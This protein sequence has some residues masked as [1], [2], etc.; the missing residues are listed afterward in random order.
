MSDKLLNNM[1][2]RIMVD[3]AADMEHRLFRMLCLLASVISLFIVIPSNIFQNIPILVNIFVGIFGF[4]T[5]ALYRLSISGRHFIMT[6]FVLLVLVLDSTW[7]LNGGT[8][9]SVT[10]YFFCA[11]MYPLIF[12]RKSLRLSL[13]FLVVANG[14]ALILLENSF[15]ALITP[16]T[17]EFDRTVDLVT[18]MLTSAFASIMMLWS[19]MKSYDSERERLLEANRQLE[20]S[21]AEI[22]TLEGLLPIC[23]GCKK[24]KEEDGSWVHVEQYISDN[25]GASFSHGMCPD[26]IS[27]YYPE[28]AD[29]MKTKKTDC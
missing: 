12:F 4:S 9:G 20:I 5:F 17:T 16:F 11:F 8:Y 23:A 1:L 10:Y 7:F 2:K 3:S 18:G 24:I 29:E 26:C 22:K 15:P 13:L 14:L 25:S 6:L 27:H 28:Y 21:M 19:V